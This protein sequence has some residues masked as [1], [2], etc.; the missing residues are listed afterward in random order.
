MRRACV[1]FRQIIGPVE[2][3]HREFLAVPFAMLDNCAVI[4]LVAAK[5]RPRLLHLSADARQIVAVSIVENIVIARLTE[6]LL[7]VLATSGMRDQ[8]L[9]VEVIDRAAEA[10][11]TWL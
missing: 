7:A 2:I 8:A 3:D 4:L 10:I 6:I 1:K 5:F 9:A 11:S